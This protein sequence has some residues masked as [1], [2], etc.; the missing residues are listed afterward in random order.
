MGSQPPSGTHLLQCGDP[1]QA[2]GGYLLHHGLPWAAG[3]Q[4]ASSW[5][6][7]QAARASLLQRLQHLLPLLLHWP[8]CLQSCSSYI[9]SLLS[10]AAVEQQVISPHLPSLTCY[11]RGT[12]TIA[13]VLS[14][15]QRLYQTLRKL[16]AVSHR[17]H[18][19]S[20][21][22]TKTLLCKPNTT[23]YLMSIL[24]L[25]P[26]ITC[27]PSRKSSTGAFSALKV[28]PPHS[29]ICFMIILDRVEGNLY[30]FQPCSVPEVESC[31]FSFRC[32]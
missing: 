21:S 32:L 2:T 25:T 22:P 5:S 31:I 9:F 4:S 1:P 19:C 26:V 3:E 20:A 27:S 12:T 10:T 30:W 8:W 11:H 13:D 28:L 29:C 14:L 7:L 15:G 24:P 18:P 16:L 6:A 23:L 17:S